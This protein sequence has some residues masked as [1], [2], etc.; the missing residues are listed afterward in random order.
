MQLVTKAIEQGDISWHAFPFN[1]EMEFA[2]NPDFLAAG[3]MTSHYLV[4]FFFLIL[5]MGF[6]GS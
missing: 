1:A 4:C 3:I 2:M 5:F 6:F